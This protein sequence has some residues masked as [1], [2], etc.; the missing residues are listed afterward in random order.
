MRISKVGI[1]GAGTMGAGI[2]ALAA[3]V[4]LPVV[5]LDIPGADDPASPDRSKPARDGLERQRKA[6]PAAFLEPGAAAR[7]TIGNTADDLER[8]A[9]CD[10]ILE[11]II[12]QPGPKQA[13]FARLEA[14]A[15][16]AI[17]TSNTSGSRWRSSSRAAHRGSGSASSARTTSIRRGI[18][19]C[20]S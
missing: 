1:I 13:L 20:S 10:W 9:D 7:I 16:D 14:I 3:S 12:E 8:L 5:L 2:A 11:A 15:P 19:T 18:C 4:G 6:K 17:V